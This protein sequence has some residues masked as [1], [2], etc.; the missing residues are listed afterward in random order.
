MSRTH[1]LLVWAAATDATFELARVEE[2]EVLAGKCI[3]CG[4]RLVVELG[5]RPSAATVE[6]IVPQH[7]DGGNELENLA[8]ACAR[9]NSGKGVRLDARRRGDP[10]LEAVIATLQTRRRERWREPPEDLR[11]LLGAFPTPKTPDAKKSARR[12]A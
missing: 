9:C 2:R 5:G 12:R 10:T 4:R 8:V 7:H 6:H 11:L 1:R 3:H